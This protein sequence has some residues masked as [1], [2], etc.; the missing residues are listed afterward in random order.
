M[1]LLTKA[2]LVSMSVNFHPFPCKDNEGGGQKNL[3][4]M[5]ARYVFLK[6]V[7]KICLSTSGFLNVENYL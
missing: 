5:I 1:I 3:K 4:L 6:V 2:D 7:L